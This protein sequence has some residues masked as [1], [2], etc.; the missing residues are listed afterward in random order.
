MRKNKEMKKK[1]YN[2]SYEKPQVLLFFYYI[3]GN[4]DALASLYTLYIY[5]CVYIPTYTHT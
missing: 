2:G 3:N 5:V 1:K 4:R